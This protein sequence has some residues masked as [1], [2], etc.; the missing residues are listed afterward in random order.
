MFQQMQYFV[1]VVINH[2][3]TKAAEVC[4]VSQSSISE[5]IKNL[6]ITLGV[7]LVTRKG[8]S[9]ELT[10]AGQY[11]YQQ[12]QQILPQLDNA[13][14][15]T[16][17]LQKDNLQKYTLKLGYLRKF[18]AQ[19][20]L[21]AVAKF[22]KAFPDV[23]VQVRSGSY[24]ELFDLMLTGE[25]DLNFS[26]LRDPLLASYENLFLTAADYTVVL[27]PELVP[28]AQQSIDVQELTS[29]PCILVAGD[30][31]VENERN[32]YRKIL[33]I[34]SE[35]KTT[36]TLGESQ[37]MAAAGQGYLLMNRR[38][39]EQIDSRVNRILTL[40]NRGKPLVQNYYAYWS[41]D[42]SGFYIESFS[43]L[44]AKQFE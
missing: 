16:H 7:D 35:F 38:T 31:Q 19:E 27:S 17:A 30:G 24:E 10:P 8:R 36:P 37:I 4:H 21:Q 28:D 44:L 6:S 29:M 41:K 3:Y 26:D 11:F 14:E 2:S 23:D 39:I 43:A 13:I 15:K 33:G 22:S 32:Y 9:F 18:G 1:A 40:T 42:N 12:C 5:Q 20:F 25:L 34:R